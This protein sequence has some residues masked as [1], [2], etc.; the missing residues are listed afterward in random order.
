[1][2][3]NLGRL[4]P[5]KSGFE[6]ATPIQ[7]AQAPAP[8]VIANEAHSPAE[9]VVARMNAGRINDHMIMQ[10]TASVEPAS[11]HLGA[12]IGTLGLRP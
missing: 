2:L 8:R 1:M 4:L 7:I 5:L 6:P 12:L 3:D 11:D 9:R 10:H